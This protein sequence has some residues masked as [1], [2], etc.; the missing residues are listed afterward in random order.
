[1]GDEIQ[2][3]VLG[4]EIQQDSRT[5][6]SPVDNSTLGQLILDANAV[7]TRLFGPLQEAVPVGEFKGLL[8]RGYQTPG[9]LQWFTDYWTG[10][11]TLGFTP[12]AINVQ[13]HDS[14]ATL[15]RY[16]EGRAAGFVYGSPVEETAGDRRHQIAAVEEQLRMKLAT[17]SSDPAWDPEGIE[18]RYKVLVILKTKPLFRQS[19]AAGP[20]IG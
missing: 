12:Y 4:Q 11:K 16:L 1:M 20:G 7:T 2:Q 17:P 15:V 13:L 3:D 8:E 10:I 9:I 19:Q 5:A 14:N 6:G 18:Y